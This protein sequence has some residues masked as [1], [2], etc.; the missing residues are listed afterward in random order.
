MRKTFRHL[1]VA[2]G[3]M[4]APALLAQTYSFS[5]IGGISGTGG[6][7]DGKGG[8]V[9]SPPMFAAPSSVVLDSSGNVYVADTNNQ[10]I[11]KITPA[12][13]VSTFVGQMGVVGATDGT[14]TAASFSAPEASA[15]DSSGNIYVADYVSATIRK[16]TSAGVVTSLAGYPGITGSANGTGNAATFNGPRGIAVDKSGNVF[17]ADSLNHV[18][19]KVT[20]SGVVTTFSG[21]VGTA[22]HVDGNAT[23]ATYNYP[24]A[25]A[26]DS[27]GILYVADTYNQTI[28]KVATDGS[29]STYVGT[30]LAAGH[31]DATGTAAKLNLP[32]GLAF[33]TSGNLYISEQ[34][35][36]TIRKVASGG[37]VTTLAGGG[38]TGYDSGRA[39]GTGT[40]ALFSAPSGLAVDS[41]GNIF[42]AD[43][44]NSLIRKITSAGV[45]TTI[46]GA[47]GVGG[48]LNGTGYIVAPTLFWRPTNLA[49]DNSGNIFVADTFGEVI[50]KIALDGTVT[51]FAG[52]SKLAGTTDG[53][54]TAASFDGPTGLA[55]DNAGNVVVADTYNHTIRQVAPDGTVSTLAGTAGTAGSADGIGKAATFNLPSGVAVD[56][57]ANAVYVA[58]YGNHTIRRIDRASG[59]VTTYAGT[60]GSMGSADGSGSSA[61][62]DF[63]RDIAFDPTSGNLVVADT[64]NHLIR[65]IAG[66]FVT[67]LAGSA[68]MT[69]SADATGASARFNSPS[70][71]AV[72]TS[73][74]IYVADSNN[75]T[76]RK[77]TPSGAVTTIGGTPG[78]AGSADGSGPV[79]R[80]DHPTGVAVDAA[81]DVF[82]AD[83]NN[84][85]IREGLVSTNSS[86]AVGG[87]TGS[88]NGSGANSTGTTVSTT[89]LNGSGS[90]LHPGGL[91]TDSLGNLYVVDTQHHSIKRI[92]TAGGISTFVGTGSAGSTDGKGTAASFNAPTGITIGSG[93]TMYVTDTGNATI[94]QITSDG[95]VTTIAGST[96]ARGNNDATG[97]AAT[98]ATPTGISIDSSL[99]TLYVTD[100]SNHTIRKVTTAGVVTTAAGAAGQPGD[101]DAIGIAA[102][103]NN[104]TGISLDTNNNAFIADSYNNTIRLMD[105]TGIVTTFAG[106]AGVSGDYDGNGNY[107]L[108]NMPYTVATAGTAVYVA[109]TGNNTIRGIS[110]DT[111]H[112]VFTLAGYPGLAGAADGQVYSA[113]FNKPQGM[114]YNSLTNYLIISDTGNELIRYVTTTGVV[115]TPAFTT[116]TSSNGGGGTLANTGGG[117]GDL[118]MD[119][120]LLL[121]G[122]SAAAGLTALGR[123]RSAARARR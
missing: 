109:D 12:G 29:A 19:R 116:D 108:F 76:I 70:G 10:V 78:V 59:Q 111:A 72:D 55:V 23:T 57:A 106:A 85:T 99:G 100:T 45:V 2:M 58:D 82:V 46:A 13:V 7:L 56:N 90:F 21:I 52:N 43:Y 33:D 110:T 98:F 79:A 97:S 53:K 105:A 9:T 28:R 27:A 15:I 91:V 64:G 60:A 103:F 63:P 31:V 86:G 40:N 17:V 95:T 102:R 115:T 93:N 87:G 68:G 65:R 83:Y 118:G 24:S 61:T 114:S 35:N 54:G 89:G 25:L 66:G 69:G 84:D 67:T 11:R 4:V 18:I 41:S 37:A 16:I 92:T 80:F 44:R 49:M 104:P 117:G 48:S 6:V 122:L 34:G 47:G 121:A 123:Q 73:G 38:A 107:A 74:N 113:L 50:R 42:L 71:V 1:A 120:V 101:T 30:T 26:F 32:A 81:G 22:G 112:S 88:V 62:F 75:D 36:N 51:T 5:T 119:F 94:R 14:G 77:V 39:D 20:Q 3:L 8:Y 96:T